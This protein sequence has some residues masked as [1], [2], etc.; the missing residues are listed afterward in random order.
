LNSDS[1]IARTAEANNSGAV[2]LEMKRAKSAE[3]TNAGAIKTT[4]DQLKVYRQEIYRDLKTESATARTAEETNAGA[5]NTEMKRA[6]KVEGTNAT[7]IKT[8]GD[9]L[10]AALKKEI[11]T[12]RTA[13]ANNATAIKTTGDSL[14]ADLKT[15][16]ATARTAEANNAG[17]VGL[18]MKRAKSAE[19]SN[20]AAIES[21]I[22]TSRAEGKMCKLAVVTEA[23]R[24]GV[25][26]AKLEASIEDIINNVDPKALDS[27]SE[28]VQAFGDAD[29]DLKATI[30][31]VL[32]THTSE[33]KTE[34]VNRIEQ[35]DINAAAVTFEAERAQDAEKTIHG[36]ISTAN[37]DIE[38]NTKM[39]NANG[40]VLT[41]HYEQHTNN[42]KNIDLHHLEFQNEVAK[43]EALDLVVGAELVRGQLEDERIEREQELAKQDRI[44][45]ESELRDDITDIRTTNAELA[46]LIDFETTRAEESED[47]LQADSDDIRTELL[48]E[49]DERVGHINEL[50]GK[51]NGVQE[52][53]SREIKAVSQELIT[54]RD[55]RVAEQQEIV[56]DFGERN[57]QL[58]LET[59]KKINEAVSVSEQ[60]LSRSIDQ[61]RNERKDA[62]EDK[63]NTYGGSLYEGTLLGGTAADLQVAGLVATDGFISFGDYW[64]I[65]VSDPVIKNG[66]LTVAPQLNFEFRTA[67]GSA[68][69]VAMPFV[70]SYTVPAN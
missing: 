38:L 33:L 19:E 49:H 55:V 54:E 8:T 35:G 58:S 70:S 57:K 20:K 44:A 67:K 23:A 13:E 61:E 31:D 6:I 27:L 48:H 11:D 62:D 16:S 18:E 17:A 37:D 10:K 40:T 2:C 66:K 32:G 36:M 63:V 43:R 4:G 45:S 1:D 52:S 65:K 14:N 7:A 22:I 21:E 68:W 50:H 41:E 5:V 26:E 51:I 64:R 9:S 30:D 12:A 42:S 24:A 47:R 25:A 39:I 53:S 34:V 46:Q 60:I 28:L 15:E 69:H 56:Q 3:E 29:K 59:A